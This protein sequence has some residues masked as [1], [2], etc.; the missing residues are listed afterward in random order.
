MTLASNLVTGASDQAEVQSGNLVTG[1]SDSATHPLPRRLLGALTPIQE[2]ILR[3][4]DLPQRPEAIMAKIG[5]THRTHFRNHQLRLLL[6][7][8]LLLQAH[9]ESLPPT[10]I[11][12]TSSHQLL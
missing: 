12:L 7:S 2:Q 5:V 10:Q 6:E 1:G 8:R 9:P 3:F 4:C 11:K